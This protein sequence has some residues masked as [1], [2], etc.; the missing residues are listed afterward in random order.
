MVRMLQRL[1]EVLCCEEP[2]D[3]E[4]D[5]PPPGSCVDG[6]AQEDPWPTS[7]HPPHNTQRPQHPADGPGRLVRA[8][9]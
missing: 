3:W 4:V 8:G 2:H 5:S 1:A 7:Q 6:Q 9:S